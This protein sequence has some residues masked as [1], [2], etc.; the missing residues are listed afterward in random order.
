M[1]ASKGRRLD[2]PLR[3]TLASH[4]GDALDGGWWPHTSSIARELP[5]LI[6]VLEQPLGHVVDIGVNWSSL[7]GPPN[8]DS[9]NWRGNALVS[10]GESRRQRVMTLSGSRGSARLLVV[11]WRTSTA[12][13]VML[14]RQAAR[15]PVRSM[16]RDTDAYRLA[17]DIV[18]AARAEDKSSATSVV[19]ST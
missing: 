12:L 7:V 6:D 11:P 2:N 16:H 10:V 1:T 9:L 14:L 18:R 5:D 19:A 4:L 8:L 13:A 17:E 3:L 15:F